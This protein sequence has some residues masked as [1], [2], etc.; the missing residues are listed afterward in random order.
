MK[1]DIKSK[2]LWSI[3]QISRH[4]FTLIILGLAVHLLIP[5]FTTL[6]HSLQ[7]LQQMAL[8]AI[9]LAIIAQIASY[10]GSGYL[11][12]AIVQLSDHKLT[13][14][15]AT[16]IVLA[17]ASLGMV[18]GGMVGIAAATYRWVQK[19][20]VTPETA[21]LA[22][23]IPGFFNASVLVLVSLIGLVH[24]LLVHQLTTL[25]A[26]S[27][28]FILLLLGGLVGLLIWGFRHRSGLARIIHRLSNRWSDLRKKE[29][30]PEKID[31]WLSGLFNSWDVLIKGGWQGP[32]FGAT[33]NL[34]FDMLTLYFLFM[35]AGHP[36]SPG[37]LLTGYGIPLLIGRVA[38]FI[39]GGIGV[40]EST[41]V[42]LYD[43]LGVPDPV[44]VVVV[45]AYRILSFWLP[46]LLGFPMIFLLQRGLNNS[47]NN[48]AS[49]SS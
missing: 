8:W 37:V 33:L 26:V 22:G 38:F 35:A 43:N 29:Y 21:G 10:L 44:S 7:V 24:L 23:I 6:E 27:F 9:I 11:L 19:A 2:S 14:G 31:N 47:S 25:Q 36:V 28:A 30:S 32:A 45:L 39:P 15:K 18:A 17:A 20:G 34:V 46:F 13:I 3:E 5:Q 48:V 12:K 16:I 42:A 4:L 41:M 49:S 1:L 40:V